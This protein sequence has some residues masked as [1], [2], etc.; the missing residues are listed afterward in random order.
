MK[1]VSADFLLQGSY[2]G[3]CRSLQSEILSSFLLLMAVHLSPQFISALQP[4]GYV[5]GAECP[6]AKVSC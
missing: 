2:F 5:S 6:L 1:E 4:T 3:H